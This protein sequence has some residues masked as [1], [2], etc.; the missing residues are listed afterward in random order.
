MASEHQFVS[1]LLLIFI[2]PLLLLSLLP[3]LLAGEEFSLFSVSFVPS[4]FLPSREEKKTSSTENIKSRSCFGFRFDAS[5][6]FASMFS[7]LFKSPRSSVRQFYQVLSILSRT[8]R[9]SGG[10]CRNK[11][12]GQRST[13]R[14][15]LLLFRFLSLDVD[16]SVTPGN[17]QAFD[18]QACRLRGEKRS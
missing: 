7:L 16:A 6:L 10:E 11:I 15:L 5:H 2:I 12:F 13:A 14:V 18:G 8:Q 1:S 9:Q 17:F 4:S 3:S